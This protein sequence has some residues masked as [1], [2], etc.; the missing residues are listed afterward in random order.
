MSK[1]QLQLY[2]AC[3]MS[4]GENLVGYNP[5]FSHAFTSFHRLRCVEAM[6]VRIYT[7]GNMLCTPWIDTGHLNLSNALK[8][9]VTT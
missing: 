9:T 3:F 2:S 5:R 6:T 1:E 4:N 8:E 7:R